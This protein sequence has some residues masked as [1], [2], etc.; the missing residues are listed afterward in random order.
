MWEAAARSTF[1]H[2]GRGEAFFVMHTQ[3]TDSAGR[4]LPYHVDDAA[5]VSTQLDA[6]GEGNG[7]TK[8]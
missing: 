8:R 1:D 3:L 4:P 6:C 5:L 7:E 2:R